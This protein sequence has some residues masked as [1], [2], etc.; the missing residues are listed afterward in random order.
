MTKLTLILHFLVGSP[1]SELIEPQ[2]CIQLL[3]TAAQVQQD[4]ATIS[5]AGHGV[6]TSVRCGGFVVDLDA[7]PSAGPCEMEGTS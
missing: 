2:H 7:K 4:G 3:A 5:R 6:I 1:L